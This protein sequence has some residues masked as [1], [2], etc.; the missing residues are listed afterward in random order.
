ML[1]CS[2]LDSYTC[3]LYITNS[4]GPTWLSGERAVFSIVA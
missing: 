4:Q 3:T 1:N 2:H